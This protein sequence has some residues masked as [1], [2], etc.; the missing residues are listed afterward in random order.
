MAPFLP[1]DYVQGTG[2]GY[3]RAWKCV[4]VDGPPAQD[5]G[6]WNLRREPALTTPAVG[7]LR[8]DSMRD[9]GWGT[10]DRGVASESSRTHCPAVRG[11][12]LLWN[13]CLTF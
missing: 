11:M 4:R 6:H 10:A 7:R 12:A 5:G 1:R 13:F 9:Y 2:N 8:Y 3:A